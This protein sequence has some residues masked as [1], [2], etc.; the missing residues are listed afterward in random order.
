MSVLRRI[1]HVTHSSAGRLRLRLSWLRRAP[2]EA[3]PLADNLVSLNGMIEAAARPWTGSVLC[4]YDPERL[5]EARIIAAVQRHT[6]ATVVVRPGEES[7]P[8]DL[9]FAAHGA[10]A[11]SLARAV[12]DSFAAMNQQVLAA[13]DGRL[14]LGVLTSLTFMTAGAA[15]VVVTR[16]LPAPPWFTLAWWA[17]RTFTTFERDTDRVPPGSSAPRLLD[18]ATPRTDPRRR[19]TKPQRPAARRRPRP[20]P[21]A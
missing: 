4:Q 10:P 7:P 3:A 20:S 8:A 14:D 5:D 17:V 12:A 21:V 15:E 9:E 6:R 18:R 2:E 11:S 1:I 19:A 13:T 16:Q